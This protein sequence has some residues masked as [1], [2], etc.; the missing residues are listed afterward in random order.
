[1]HSWLNKRVRV[2]E[3]RV[4][5]RYATETF[6]LCDISVNEQSAKH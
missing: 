6:Q 5:A 4:G 1:M 2:H 3:P